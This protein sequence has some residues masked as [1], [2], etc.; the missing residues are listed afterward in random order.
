MGSLPI[1][2]E[3]LTHLNE[4]IFSLLNY[5]ANKSEKTKKIVSNDIVDVKAV[6]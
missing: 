6:C 1:H 3:L 4:R 5:K 2:L